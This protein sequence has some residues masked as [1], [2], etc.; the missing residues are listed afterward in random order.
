MRALRNIASLIACL[1]GGVAIPLHAATDSA[2]EQAFL[3]EL[4]VVLTPSRLVQPLDEAPNAITVIDRQM[5]RASGFRRI[6]ELLR[7]VPGMYVG[8]SN[9]YSLFASYHGTT[10]NF[11]R[12]MQVLVDGRSVYLPPY[13]MVIWDDLPVLLDDIER[14]EVIRGPAAASHGANSSQGV[15]NIITRDAEASTANQVSVRRGGNAIKDAEMTFAQRGENFSQRFS[16]GYRS[17]GGYD[18]A[19]FNDGNRTTMFNWRAAWHPGGMDTLDFQ[20]GHSQSVRGEG[21]AGRNQTPERDTF[22]GHDFQQLVWTR[23]LAGGDEWQ[24]RYHHTHN[25]ADDDQPAFYRDGITPYP[26]VNIQTQRHDVEAQHTVNWMPNN[27]LVWGGGLRLD[28]VS[29][30]SLFYYRPAPTLRQW[31]LFAHD[32]WRMRRDLL[33][34]AG[35]MWQ[36]DGMGHRNVSPRLTLNYHLTSN[37]TLRIGASLAYRDPATVEE[38]GNTD[39]ITPGGWQAYGGL[40]PERMWAREIAY[41]GHFPDA[42]W[43]ME[44]R[45]FS[46]HLHGQIFL[47]PLRDVNGNFNNAS[48]K[49]L[50]RVRYAGWEGSVKYQRE[51][52]M[53]TLNF[54][55]QHAACEADG[56]PTWMSD[57]RVQAWTQGWLEQCP[58]IVPLN[59]GS[60]L[61]EHRFTSALSVSAG[62]YFQDEV[63]VL[64]AQQPQRF[65]HRMDI[66]ITRS[67]GK[68][69]EA[70]GGE[71]ALVVQNLFR[72]TH[73]EYA[74]VPQ[75][76][77]PILDRRAYLITTFPY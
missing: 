13:S 50:Y 53:L 49:N 10:D 73:T 27:R 46:D 41:L 47:D 25:R 39:P 12:R 42:G 43:M 61:A 69:G 28:G 19:Q 33:L 14:I 66:K 31:R 51:G 60:V 57:P 71:V 8:S 32:E 17:D 55:R 40:Q 68:R 74:N 30:S 48:F 9:G 36:D 37:H 34:N 4:P 64:D 7:L 21:I 16:A 76:G 5:I 63:Q 18:L 75:Q 58:R 56:T 67:F 35:A 52:D 62:Y 20:A 11:A 29:S 22:A 24:L 65:M 15:I 23:A 45:L 77:Q 38:Y 59:Q 26:K 44:T 70:G 54:S 2:A 3:L 72:D 6:P 1:W